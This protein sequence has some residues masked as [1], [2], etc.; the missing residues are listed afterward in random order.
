[1]TD[2][3]TA[4]K[5]RIEAKPGTA[6]KGLVGSPSV[7]VLKVKSGAVNALDKLK[8]Y[9]HTLITVLGAVLVGINELSPI[10]DHLPVS[11]KHYVTLTILGITALVNAL[12]S[13][14]VWVDQ[15]P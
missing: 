10:T 8:G 6:A 2:T 9:Y 1:M 15:L 7:K 11:D 14:E 4:T 13:N 5:Y 3:N 12:K